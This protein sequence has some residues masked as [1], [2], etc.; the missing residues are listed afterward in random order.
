MITRLL[1]FALTLSAA[2]VAADVWSFNTPSGNIE[3]WVGE[4]QNASDLTCTIFKRSATLPGY[5]KCPASRGL[6]LFMTHNGAVQASCEPAG[7]RPSGGQSV[8]DYGV[9]GR[10][11]GFTCDSSRKGLRCKNE[12]GRGFFLSRAVQSVF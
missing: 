11:G 7:A 8:A 12:R 6:T 4:S 9:Q 10:F 3:C 5:T 1:V 2:P